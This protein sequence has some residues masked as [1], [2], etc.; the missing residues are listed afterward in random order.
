MKKK[1]VNSQLSNFK[2]YLNYRDK[3]MILAQNVFNY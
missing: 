2:T 1:V 3:M